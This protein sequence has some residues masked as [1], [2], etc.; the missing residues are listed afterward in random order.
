GRLIM[1]SDVSASSA[2]ATVWNGTPAA[3]GT[4]F[5][6]SLYSTSSPFSASLIPLSFKTFSKD[7]IAGLSEITGQAC[8]LITYSTAAFTTSGC[9][10]I[11][12]SGGAGAKRLGFI[13]TR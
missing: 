6:N 11:A 10:T 12:H 4:D 8:L 9:V 13:T 2:I 1:T 7:P 5:L 3:T